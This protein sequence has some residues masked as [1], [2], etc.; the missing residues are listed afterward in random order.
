MSNKVDRSELDNKTLIRL[1]SAIKSFSKN[2]HARRINFL[3][4]AAALVSAASPNLGRCY[5]KEM[6]EI[7]NKHTIRLDASIKREVCKGCNTFL[8]PGQS[9]LISAEYE[10]PKSI[11]KNDDEHLSKEFDNEIAFPFDES[12]YKWIKTTCRVCTR[13]RKIRITSDS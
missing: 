4:Q 8:M 6:N 9:V 10:H 13:T 12:G 3:S 7:A 2:V 5:I 1:D 11:M